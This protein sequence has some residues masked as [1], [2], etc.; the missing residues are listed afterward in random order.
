MKAMGDTTQIGDAHD[1]SDQDSD[2][3]DRFTPTQTERDTLKLVIE[4]YGKLSRDLFVTEFSANHPMEYIVHVRG[5]LYDLAVDTVPD[6]PDGQLRIRKD[7]QLSGGKLATDKMAEDIYQLVQYLQGDTAVDIKVML[8][9]KS[10]KRLA[11]HHTR[12]NNQDKD[13]DSSRVGGS[14]DSS[15]IM[16]QAPQPEL[17][18]QIL[19]EM[20]TDRDLLLTEIQELKQKT[21]SIDWL[22]QEMNS[23]KQ[24]VRTNT[25]RVAKLEG[26]LLATEGQGNSSVT[27][28][29][30]IHDISQELDRLSKK[31]SLSHKTISGI[32]KHRVTLENDLTEIRRMGR[33]PRAQMGCSNA[34]LT[35]CINDIELHICSEKNRQ[36]AAT[37]PSNT[38]HLVTATHKQRER[39][40][41]VDNELEQALDIVKT[42]DG[43]ISQRPLAAKTMDYA[44]VTRD[45]VLSNN[46]S[47]K[48]VITA[49]VHRSV[50]LD[51][52]KE[53][54]EILTITVPSD[55]SGNKHVTDC[56]QATDQNHELA[57]FIPVKH[58]QRNGAVFLAGVAL[59]NNNVDDTIHCVFEYLQKRGCEAKSVH[60][61]KK[62][63]E[64]LSVKVV[65]PRD[66]V[67]VV[68]ERGYWPTGIYCREWII[69][70]EQ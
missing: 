17:W 47:N 68:V 19:V 5:S 40:Y 15:S 45:T 65:L 32:Q 63:D 41:N 33:D 70:Q 51:K 28:D 61:L 44:A 42:S 38:T 24:E 35:S 2:E 18:V 31:C 23:L 6:T 13:H 9:E 36:T 26:F 55:T 46:S 3:V 7:T 59:R 11:K 8:S 25:T 49:E 30:D 22:K 62:N 57:G 53:N 60:K 39:N 14:S 34:T 48:Q 56:E 54:D 16:F 58:K 43:T 64:T 37:S 27:S 10:R 67:D 20:R 12:V 69:N 1:D 21:A 66:H 52:S 29:K 4:Q 50:E